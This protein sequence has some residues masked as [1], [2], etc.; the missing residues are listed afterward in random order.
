MVL[1]AGPKDF[2]VTLRFGGGLHTRASE[3]EIEDREAA[4]GSNFLLD[5]DTKELK[6]R[7]PFDLIGTVPNAQQIRGGGSLLK[8]DG[9][10]QAF[11]QGGN[12]VY[13]WDGSSFNASPVLATVNSSA[14]LR[15][16]WRTHNWTLDDKLLVTDLSLIETVKEWDGGSTMS[17]VAFKSTPST[18]F[19]NFFA[20]Y[21]SVSN[22]RAV[23]AHVKDGGGTFPHMIVGSLRGD[24]SR[25]SVADRPSSS[26]SEEDPYFLLTPDLRPINGLVESF[27]TTIVS[28]QMGKLFNLSGASS[29]DFAFSDFYAGSGAAGEESL[30]YVGNDVIYGRQGRIESVSDTDRFGD[31]EA[32]DITK[33]IADQVRAYTGWLTCYNSRLNRVYLF[34]TGISEC[35]VFNTSMRGGDLSPW[36]RWVTSHSLAFQP[37]FGMS[38]LDPSDALEYVNMGDAQGNLYRLEGSGTSGDGG[39]TSIITEFES[40]LFSLP[41]DMEAYNVQGYIK[42]RKNE[43]LSVELIF[44]YAGKSIFNQSITVNLPAAERGPVYSGGSYYSNGEYYGSISGRL[45]RQPIYVPGQGNEFQIKVRAISDNDFSIT[46]IGLR[47][48]AANKPSA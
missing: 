39:T 4:D 24:Y 34:P 16:H 9:T 44:E 3:E 26:L 11:I 25:I 42:Y 46:E 12:K 8:A 1:K 7:R 37:T 14:K 36:M 29:K 31:S 35:W 5:L 27:G 48:T 23:F 28:T 10:V 45:S 38:M 19:G 43:A 20:K 18:S 30:A 33:E 15:G 32:D 40:K 47:F 13:E 2:D 22:E 6:P 17:A 21:C 41:L